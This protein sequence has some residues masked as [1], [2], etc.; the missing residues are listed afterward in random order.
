MG[1]AKGLAESIAGLVLL[2]LVFLVVT[3]PVTWL[4]ML[5]IGNLGGDLSY[6]GTLPLGTVVSMLIGAASSGASGR[7]SSAY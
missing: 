7:G 2:F 4:L 1:V 5:F 3:F 6:W